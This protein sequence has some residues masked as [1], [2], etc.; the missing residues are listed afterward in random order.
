MEIGEQSFSI[1][2]AEGIG[3][4]DEIEVADD[5]SV[6]AED[7]APSVVDEVSQHGAAA[8]VGGVSSEDDED[9]GDE[10]FAVTEEASKVSK[11]RSA[12]DL[13][14]S[15]DGS[16]HLS[17]ISSGDSDS[18]LNADSALQKKLRQK[19]NRTS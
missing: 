19:L 12:M 4:D 11:S 2:D 16:Y 18:L 3:A 5:I 14:D 15:L 7:D 6:A 13:G 8:A 17:E 9:Y 10:S 1:E